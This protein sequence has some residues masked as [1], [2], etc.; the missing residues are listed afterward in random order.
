MSY[1][2]IAVPLVP[3]ADPDAVGSS[4]IYAASFAGPKENSAL[5]AFGA[6]R[7]TPSSMTVPHGRFHLVERQ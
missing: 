7:R 6:V 4:V 5:G 3:S 1:E 2:Q